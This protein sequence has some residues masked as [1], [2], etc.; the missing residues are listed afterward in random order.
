MLLSALKSGA[1]FDLASDTITDKAVLRSKI[2]ALREKMQ[3]LSRE[4]DALKT[5]ETF[6]II[7][8]LDDWDTYF[9]NVKQQLTEEYNVLLSETGQALIQ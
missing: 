8:G 3:S 1:G 9:D 6:E 4:V 5:E 7:Q 2:D